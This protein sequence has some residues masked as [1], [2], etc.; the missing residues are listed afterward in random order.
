LAEAGKPFGAP[1]PAEAL[2]DLD[3]HGWELH[4]VANDVAET[5]TWRAAPGQAIAMVAQWYDEASSTTCCRS[6]A[7]PSRG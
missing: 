3:A 5:T 4:R 6:M 2:A 7:A 1:I